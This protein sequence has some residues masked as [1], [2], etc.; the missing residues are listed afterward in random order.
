MEAASI[1][2]PSFPSSCLGSTLYAV[3]NGGGLGNAM[4]ELLG[5]YAIAQ[6]VKRSAVVYE[7]Y[8]ADKIKSISRTFPLVSSFFVDAETNNC[9]TPTFLDV[10]YKGCCTYDPIIVDTISKNHMEHAVTLKLFYLQSFKF[11]SD[12]PQQVVRRFFAAAKH[13][14]DAVGDIFE[15][16]PERKDLNVCVHIRRGDFTNS[17][18]ALASDDMF[19]KLAVDYVLRKVKEGDSRPPYTYVMSDDAIWAK[20]TLES[21][22]RLRVAIPDASS[23]PGVEWEF[24]RQFCDHVLLTASVSTYGYWIGYHSRGQKVYYNRDYTHVGGIEAQLVPADFWPTHWIPIVY[25]SGQ[26]KV[27]EHEYQRRSRS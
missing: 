1:Q 26:Q 25:D 15:I 5:L 8:M 13:L 9:G 3:K 4:F 10:F 7:R 23:P 19:T 21:Y 27:K 24:S 20:K 18:E 22:E 16:K 2:N 12:L 6:T 14:R 11:I 17:T